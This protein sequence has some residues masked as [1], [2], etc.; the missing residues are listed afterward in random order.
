MY[1][2]GTSGHIPHNHNHNNQSE[3]M[4]ENMWLFGGLKR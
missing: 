4:K 1:E 2:L 3:I